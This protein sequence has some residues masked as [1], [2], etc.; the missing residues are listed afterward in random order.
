MIRKN[1]KIFYVNFFLDEKYRNQGIGSYAFECLKIISH[2]Q[3]FIIFK[4][5]RNADTK[6]EIVNS[7]CFQIHQTNE[8]SYYLMQ[9]EKISKF[10]DSK[11]NIY[12]DF[13][14][15]CD[16]ENKRQKIKIRINVK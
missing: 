11:E 1:E 12:L 10:F 3:E 16:D 4:E 6:N 9:Y 8:S 5:D 2:L 14:K 15:L 13:I 7:L